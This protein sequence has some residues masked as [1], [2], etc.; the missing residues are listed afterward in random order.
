MARPAA[1]PQQIR[2]R[3]LDAAEE[4]LG[5]YGYRK[6]T[7]D[8][9][10]ITA[11]VA[12]GSIYLHFDSKEEIA[13]A[14][15]DRLIDE[16]LVELK[17][18][19]TSDRPAAQ[20]LREMLVMRILFRLERVHSYRETIDQ[21]VAAIRPRLVAARRE[22]HRR[23]ASLFATVIRDGVSRLELRPCVARRVAEAFVIA[24][25]ALLPADLRPD[26]MELS[27]V[28]AR[29]EMIADLL[30]DGVVRH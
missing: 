30:I 6:M 29:V 15:I 11:G 25:N 19:A 17:A 18:V 24:T 13:I 12:K 22:H 8:D 7:I 1:D 2:E 27:H 16:L 3:I 20:R 23:E 5:R 21:V 14:R 26:E 10:A 9:L 4:L 28:R